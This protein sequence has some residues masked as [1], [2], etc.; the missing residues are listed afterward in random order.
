MSFCQA[1]IKTGKNKGTRCNKKSKENSVYCGIHKG[2]SNPP[3]QISNLSP[4]R[5]ERQ[6]HGFE[7]ESHIISK[8]NLKSSDSYTSKYDAY[9][10]NIP[11]QIKCIK[12]GSSIELGDWRRN[13][14]KTEDFILIIGFW[15]TEK[16]NIIREEI[17][18]IDHKIYIKH[19]NFDD[20]KIESSIYTELN[21]ISNL[22]S[23]D[24]NWD[25]FRNK[26]TGLWPSDNLISI[27][28]KRDHKT[29][30]RMQCAI[31]YQNLDIF[32]SIFRK[33][34]F[35]STGLN[36]N[37][38][39]EYYTKADI[40]SDCL[41]EISNIYDLDSFDLIIEPSAGTGAFSDLLSK[42]NTIFLD[43]TPKKDNIIKADFLEYQFKEYN[44][45]MIIGNPPFGKQSCLAK[46]FIKKSSLSDVIAF[47]LPRSFKKE[48]MFSAFPQNFHK[49]F[50]KDL[51][52]NSF[53]F[54]EKEY[55]V[56]CMFQIWEKRIEMRKTKEK[57]SPK[58]YIFVKDIDETTIAFRRVGSSAGKF[59][60]ENILKLSPQ[61]HYFINFSEI[62][63]RN[64]LD[65]IVW[66]TNNTV[67]PKSISKQELICK[68]NTL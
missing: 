44:K 32:L 24:E 16:D 19:L 22:K 59:I 46:K 35:I 63:N 26:Y 8:Y 18:Y 15:Q 58:N 38:N 53:I 62:P 30:K 33:F 43:I 55:D 61:S 45:I 54:N 10:N 39:E 9:Y 51:P 34:D 50:E 17:F 14:N 25:N 64:I 52:P 2:L 40:A 68:L 67:G 28:F 56:P 4:E 47:I 57:E 20:P 27:R 3:S 11:I 60:Y 1:D 6:K 42:Y 41:K 23:D 21:L 49:V 5:K 31:P 7:Y 13:K 65:N 36:R 29:Q 12:Y 48:S 66:E 37:N